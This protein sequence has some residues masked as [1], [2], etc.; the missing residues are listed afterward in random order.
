MCP[1]DTNSVASLLEAL[2]REYIICEF[3]AD[4]QQLFLSKNNAESIR[5]F[6]KRGFRYHVAELDGRIVGFVGVRDN[7]HLY[8]LFVAKEIHHQGLARK[9]WHVARAECIVAG[10]PGAFT[11]NSSNNAVEVYE[12]LGFVR[13]APVQNADGVLFNP[14]LFQPA[15]VDFDA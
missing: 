6:V 4:A 10:N 11:V 7:T 14:M 2:A 9:L 5:E 3:A 13:T 12:R 15:A 1:A 8:H